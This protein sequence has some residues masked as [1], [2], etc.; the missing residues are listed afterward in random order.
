MCKIITAS[1][2][3]SCPLD[4]IPTCLLKQCTDVLTHVITK[5]INS[6]LQEGRVPDCWKVALVIPLFKKIGLELTFK[7]FRPV[8]NLPFIAKSTERAVISQLL[9]HCT[10]YA[11]LPDNQSSYR[12]GHST[13]TA[14]L[15]VQNDI[16][17]NMDRQEV[18]LLVLLDLSAAFDTIEHDI[19]LEILEEEFGVIGN[20]KSWI[21][22][23]LSSRTQ[24]VIIEHKCSKNIQLDCGVPQ[25][26]CLGSVL[27]ILYASGIFNIVKKHLPNAHGYADD[28][29]LYLSF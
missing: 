8:S 2:N 28:T 5:L 4:R 24:R 27:F 18:T 15:K 14:L 16:L 26:S 20:A 29:Q 22:S 23:F 9:K 13:E 17:M 21:S 19:L 11:P 25:G 7:N 10:A 6:S 1:S 3:A 12:Q